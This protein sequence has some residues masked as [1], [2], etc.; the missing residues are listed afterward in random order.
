[1]TTAQK[2]TKGYTEFE[3]LNG[4]S[5]HSVFELTKNLEIPEEEF[6]THFSSLTQV[7]RT[8]LT[9][10]IT[11][12]F[13][14][15]DADP[16]Y[17]TFSA[18]EKLLSLYFTLFEQLKMQRSYLLMKYAEL[19]QTP[20]ILKDFDPFLEQLNARVETILLEAKAQEEIQERPYIGRHY[21]KGF[22]LAFFYLFRVWIKDESAEFSTTDAAIEKSVNLSFDLLSESPLDA[23]L[24]FGKFAI[25]TKVF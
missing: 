23:L 15:M 16:N 13:Q 6:Y 20:A 22:K 7:R 10:L 24:D 4:R 21:A 17:E 11:E 8:V 12:T 3:L 19:K 1:M 18:R 14:V 2:I 9:N 5:P 25:K